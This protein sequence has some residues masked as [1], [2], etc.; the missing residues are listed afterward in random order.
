MESWWVPGTMFMARR[1][2]NYSMR[3]L[4]A[5]YKIFGALLSRLYREEYAI[6]FKE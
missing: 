3:L 6:N 4:R 2:I 5:P 1:T